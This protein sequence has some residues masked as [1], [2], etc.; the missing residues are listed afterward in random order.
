[1]AELAESF[2]CL[3]LSITGSQAPFG[4]GLIICTKT[5]RPDNTSIIDAR[6]PIVKPPQEIMK[7]TLSTGWKSL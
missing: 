1:M 4:R 5:Y 6:N 7:P 3:K 2:V